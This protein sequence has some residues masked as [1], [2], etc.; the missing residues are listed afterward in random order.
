LIIKLIPRYGGK[1]AF[2]PL[3]PADATVVVA[4]I[5]AFPEVVAYPG[6]FPGT[7]EPYACPEPPPFGAQ[8]D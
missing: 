5:F 6:W 8:L 2:V 4:V 1:L 7:V 3:T